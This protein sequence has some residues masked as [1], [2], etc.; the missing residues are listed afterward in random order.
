[1]SRHESASLRLRREA[2]ARW[3]LPWRGWGA[4][5]LGVLGGTVLQVQQAWLSASAL[6]GAVLC[7]GLCGLA[8]V[9][10]MPR[11]AG[12]VW[13]ALV[14]ALAGAVAWGGAG[15]RAAQLLQQALAPELEGRDLV[16][17][18]RVASLPQSGDWGWRFV[19]Q[20]EAATLLGRPVAVP[21]DVLLGWNPSQH[22]ASFGG[23][24]DPDDGR[25]L[26]DGLVGV[27]GLPGS[28]DAVS[29]SGPRP[30][31][32]VPGQRWRF[33]ARLKRV[34]GARNPGGFDYELWL[35]EQGILATG[36]VRARS[37]S[38]APRLLAHTAAYPVERLRH[39]V[40]EAIVAKLGPAAGPGAGVGAGVVVA[41]VT[42]D[43][44]SIRR[45]DW[46]LFRQ[47]GV[48]HLMSISGLHITLLA[49]LSARGL[50]WLWRQTARW[51]GAWA[52]A[53]LW[54]PAP[55][56]GRW[57][58]VLVALGYSVFCGWGIPA[59]R[60]V[61]M[62]VLVCALQ[63]G[64]RRWPWPSLWSMMVALVLLWD[65]WACL[66]PGFWLSFVAV[67][68]L[69]A[70]DVGR[71]ANPAAPATALP[72]K[73]LGLVLGLLREQGVLG[74]ALAPLSL[75]LFGQVSVVGLVA[76]LV[77]VPWVTAVVTPLALLGC[78]FSPLWGLAQQALQ[79][80]LWGLQWMAQWP[81]ATWSTA[82]AP[83]WAALAGGLGGLL[84]VG[85]W[86][87]AWRCLGLPL[88]VPVLLWQVPGPAPGR[89]ELLAVDVG[90]GTAVWLRTATQGLLYDAGPRYS[91]GSDAG[92]RV[93]VPL[94]RAQGANL[95]T[96][97]LSH[98]DTDH[99]GGAA[100]VLQAYP[101]A[102]LRASWNGVDAGMGRPARP[103]VAGERWLWDGVRFEVLHPVAAE[104]KPGARSNALSCV[105]RVEDAQGRTALLTGDIERDQERA[106][107]ARGAALRA[108]FLLVPHHG[109]STSS[110][111]EFLQAVQPFVAVVQA[112]YR[113]RFGHPAERVMARY[114]AL[115]I[116]RAST[117]EC[118]AVHW[119]SA[120]PARWACQRTLD[121][122]YW[123]WPQLP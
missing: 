110:S 85:P 4:L 95:N 10:L 97:V 53:C 29:A 55:V 77:A 81:G 20:V 59:Q 57:A 26:V 40:R 44:R 62:L 117:P 109:S 114:A 88:M 104:L 116:A 93:L 78:V 43:Q 106:L 50:G 98:R 2:G 54:C 119:S 103:C 80:L 25:D 112:G 41:L 71:A 87:A 52:R 111:E 18:G 121:R 123:H 24:D 90:Q 107:L 118:G 6:Y 113:N 73:A 72:R 46:V 12:W 19:L 28:G 13:L 49:W 66:Q 30:D 89:F 35:W 102:T 39:R 22:P 36:W 67:G 16:L 65:P 74:L 79:L 60:T 32:P 56:L 34:H 99:T 7:L 58:G 27:E 82:V 86:P 105:L 14:G 84:C 17:V 51:P 21:P 5:G 47:T 91:P 23:D 108:D 1:M 42:G 70:T 68:I 120:E 15:L 96:L 45:E 69:F 3:R 9:A 122:R 100:A 37:A 115:N 92:E 75:L 64:G 76:N 38:E 11:R 33:T 61:G 8:G 94:L 48:A 101:Q 63:W 83:V 31:G